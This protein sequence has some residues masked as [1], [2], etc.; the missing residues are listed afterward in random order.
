LSIA[1]WSPELDS[2]GNSLMGIE[3]LE[4]FTTDISSSIF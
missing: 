4:R 3:T 1:V 2:H